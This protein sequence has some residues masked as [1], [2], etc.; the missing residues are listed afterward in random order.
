MGSSS[1]SRRRLAA[2]EEGQIS[3]LLLLGLIPIVFLLALVFNTAKQ[4]SHKIQLQNAADASAASGGVWM[5]RGMNLTV[6]NNNGMAEV[7]SVM[8]AVRS[9]R[10]TVSIMNK[11]VIPPL[12]LLIEVPGV[13]FY[14]ALLEALEVA[15]TSVDTALNSAGGVGW[16]IMR[17]L[18]KLNQVIKKVMPVIIQAEAM[19]YARRN[20]AD[21]T[22]FIISGARGISVADLL[23]IM[24]LGRAST[25]AVVERAE[26]CQLP[27][28]SILGD[29]VLAIYA[30]DAPLA[31]LMFNGFVKQNVWS[32]K[33]TVS[34]P[35][36]P[37]LR[38]PA[39]PPRAMILTDNP[40]RSEL[41]RTNIPEEYVDLRRTRRFLQLLMIAVG[42]RE[43]AS[44]IGGARFPNETP[45]W[46][47][48]AQ[49]TYGQADVYNP[50]HWGMFT[51]DWRAKLAKAS[52][53]EEKKD[54]LAKKLGL[55]NMG[56][57]LDWSFVNTH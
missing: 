31:L 41:A 1:N 46:L 19:D 2:D 48:G 12:L 14:I 24:P 32:L 51:Q 53:F 16:T 8:I 27:K 15:L 38:W 45:L 10:Y 28:V 49:F 56:N 47:P 20:G 4:T 18:D 36:P 42:T 30:E 21:G 33:N 11:I 23:P 6:L 55:G 40:I 37:P 52:L 54:A 34:I 5:A 3:V 43:R 35:V 44:S 26:D 22:S 7:L 50:T 17:A 13:A 57:Y 9:L 25:K 39:D 29:I